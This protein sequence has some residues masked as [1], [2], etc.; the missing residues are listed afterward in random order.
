M[1]PTHALEYEHELHKHESWLKNAHHKEEYADVGGLLATWGNGDIWT[2]LL[3]RT[4][5]GSLV[6]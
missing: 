6:L 2:Q 4:M 3:P 5:S 1:G